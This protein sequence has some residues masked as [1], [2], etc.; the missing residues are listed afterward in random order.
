M[1][2]QLEDRIKK[3]EQKQSLGEMVFAAERINKQ[4][5]NKTTGR[6][7][8]LIKWKGWSPKYSTWEPEENILDPRLIDLFKAKSDG[9]GTDTIS[10]KR[11]PKPKSI[12]DKQRKEVRKDSSSSDESC[13]SDEEDENKT[14][15]RTSERSKIK[16]KRKDKSKMPSFLSQTSSGRTP[17]ATARY[18]A[19]SSEPPPK[20]TQKDTETAQKKPKIPKPDKTE[21]TSLKSTAIED[22]L[23]ENSILNLEKD[24]QKLPKD[25]EVLEYLEPPKLEPN[26]PDD[27]DNVEAI[28]GNI[29][30]EEED[31]DGDLSDNGS[32]SEYEYEESYTLTEWFPPDFWRS[33][34]KVAESVIVT[35]VTVGG[36]TVTMRESKNPEGFFNPPQ[37]PTCSSNSPPLTPPPV[38]VLPLISAPSSTKII[39]LDN[40]GQILNNPYTE[41]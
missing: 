25:Q 19:E 5:I 17:K 1:L 16:R 40:E 34:V 12:K 8:Y 38:L 6:T 10:N 3:M 21:P 11:G 36:H 24:L 9:V 22:S 28:N 29:S 35:D 13:S 32:S 37:T 4:R 14:E 2:L 7:E 15:R 41:Q 39:P 33:G 23:F 30:E 20:K 26:Y 27:T 31:E 18:V